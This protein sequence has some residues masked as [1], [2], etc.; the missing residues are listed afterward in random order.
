MRL[1][2]ALMRP[3]KMRLFRIT[4]MRLPEQ[5]QILECALFKIIMKS[6][7]TIKIKLWAHCRVHA[8]GA[9]GKR[10]FIFSP[11]LVMSNSLLRKISNDEILF[12]FY[13]TILG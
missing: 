11:K 3:T 12:L 2:S 9:P 1:R 8:Y 7:L 6:I 10:R 4:K 13:L 5:A